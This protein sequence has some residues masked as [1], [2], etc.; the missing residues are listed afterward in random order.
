MK[1][2]SKGLAAAIPIA[3]GYVPVAVT[4]GLIARTF[5]LS[6]MDA[7]LASLFIFAGSSQFLAIGAY[8]AAATAV[9]L[10]TEMT[11]QN[12]AWI[13]GPW[14]TG[15]QLVVLLQI[16]VAGWLLN[17]RHLLMSSVV[18]EH[19]AGARSRLARN[20]L[21]FGVTDEVFGVA[22]LQIARDGSIR[23]RYLAGLELGAYSAWV[24][25][26][27]LGALVGDIL[28]DRLRVAM[29][30]AL[31]ALFAALLAGQ[32][33]SARDGARGLCMRLA[34]AAVT[35][36]GTNAVLRFVVGLDAGS[37]FPVAMIVGAGFAAVGGRSDGAR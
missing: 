9:S 35:A 30:L 8:G 14:P 20:L 7:T 24:A 18:A 37:A 32:F 25:G 2:F 17:L 6:P 22:G 5:G 33:R 16:V 29:G 36:A 11:T 3:S 10:G 15:A 27:A 1:D 19:L 13:V 4:F 28:P 31:Y 12:A 23:A 34:V 21:A 26:T